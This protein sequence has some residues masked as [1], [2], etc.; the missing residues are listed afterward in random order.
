[1]PTPIHAKTSDTEM[2]GIQEDILCTTD[3]EIS[4]TSGSSLNLETTISCTDVSD[5]LPRGG[6]SCHI[7]QMS[8]LDNN[9]NNNNS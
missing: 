6:T 1:M 4:K 3:E 9:N 2:N 7:E 5:D 8:S